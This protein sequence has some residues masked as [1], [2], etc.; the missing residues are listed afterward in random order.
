MAEKFF[1]PSVICV[2]SKSLAFGI[3][4]FL[5]STVIVK[6]Q[7]SVISVKTAGMCFTTWS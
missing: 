3:S 2:L 7:A 1:V 5:I 6:D 4:K